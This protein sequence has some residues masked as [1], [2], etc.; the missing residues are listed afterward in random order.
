MPRARTPH[1][2][3]WDLTGIANPAHRRLF[4]DALG[5][6]D[7]PFKRMRRT[8]G[9][10]V[11]VTVSDI[12]R[13]AST[14]DA[15]GVHGHPHH[16][17]EHGHLLGDPARKAALGLYWL[18]TAAHPAGRVE[19]DVAL[20]PGGGRAH[21][22]LA[23]EVFLA[24]A[25]HAVDYGALTR[26]QRASLYA[27]LHDTPDHPHHGPVQT[28]MGPDDW[29]EG[30]DGGYWSWPGERWMGLFM[31]AF[32]PS[33]ARPLEPRQPWTHRYDSTDVGRVREIVLGTR[34]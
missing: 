16:G 19:V 12:S 15:D 29:F 9:K 8:T 6:C 4:W 1:S 34:G 11:P 28:E 27:L 26:T 10:R 3:S 2:Y 31:A 25:A 21:P 22:E 32:A 23:V 18:P 7:F 14:L 24:E 33:L 5:A 17:S 30:H 20:M 13:Y